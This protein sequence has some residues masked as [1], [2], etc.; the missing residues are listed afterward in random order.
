LVKPFSDKPLCVPG[1]GNVKAVNTAGKTCSLC[2]TVLPGNEDIL[3][4]NDVVDST[5]LAVPDTTY[6]DGTSAQ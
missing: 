4:P 1:V 3:I 6:W 2:Q 5:I